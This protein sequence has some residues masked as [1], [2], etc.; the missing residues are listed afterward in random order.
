MET[1]QELRKRLRQTRR[2]ISLQQQEMH[3]SQLATQLS[4]Q[5]FFKQAQHIAAY[6]ANDGEISPDKAIYAALA[7]QKQCYLPKIESF[8]DK[9]MQF[10]PYTSKTK[11]H[12]NQYGI[13]E[14][15]SCAVTPLCLELILVPLVAFDITGRRLGMGGGFYDRFLAQY[16]AN[17]RPRLVGLA[18][19]AQKVPPNTISTDSWDIQM[20]MIVTESNLYQCLPH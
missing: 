7:T 5:T 11:L 2:L 1:K 16:P 19:E 9:K 17:A 14:P 12:T 4:I 8:I 3:A 20:D 15:S 6:I 18:H 10:S 13:P